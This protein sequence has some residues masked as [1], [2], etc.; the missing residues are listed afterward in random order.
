M[1]GWRVEYLPAMGGSSVNTDEK[2]TLELAVRLSV[3]RGW[4]RNVARVIAIHGPDGRSISGA[5]ME[6]LRKKAR[7]ID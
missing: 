3:D 5:E 6:E 7:G 1:S 4:E 2:S